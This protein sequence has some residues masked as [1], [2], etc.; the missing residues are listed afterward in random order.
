[1]RIIEIVDSLGFTVVLLVWCCAALWYWLWD[2]S[3]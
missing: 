1:M 2:G 3:L